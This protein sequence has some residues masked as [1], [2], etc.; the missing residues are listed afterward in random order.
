MGKPAREARAARRVR[1]LWGK[2]DL[3]NHYVYHDSGEDPNLAG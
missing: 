1:V 2:G 3:L